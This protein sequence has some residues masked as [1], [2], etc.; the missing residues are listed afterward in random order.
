MPQARIRWRAK[1]ERHDR[2]QARQQ[3]NVDRVVMENRHHLESPLAAQEIEIHVRDH[4]AGQIALPLDA[5]HA[6]LQ[7]DQPAA[8]QPQLPQSARAEQQVEV[9]HALE[10]V[11]RARHAKARFQQRLVVRLAVVRDEHV[12]LRQVLGEPPQ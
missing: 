3:E 1:R 2:R 4:L 7:I 6:I 12:E 9:L 11:P 5:E 10:G 8:L